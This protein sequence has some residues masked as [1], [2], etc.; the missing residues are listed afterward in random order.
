MPNI[1]ANGINLHYESFGED[2]A[3]PLVLIM[4]I[5]GQ[6]IQWDEDFC[7]ALSTEGFRV[8]RFDNRD[9]GMSEILDH[10]GTPDINRLMLQRALGSRIR[11]PYTLDD[12]AE[13]TAGL[14]DALGLQSAHIVGMSLGGMVAQ[15]LAL[16]HPQRVRSLGIIMSAPGELLPGLP[17]LKAFAALTYRSKQQ[18]EQAA[19]DYQLNFF[20]VVGAAPHRTP[21][22]RVRQLAAL[23]YQRGAHPRGFARQFAAILASPGRSRRL[24]DLRVPTV[25]LHGD[26][27]PLITHW[28]GR[29]IAARIPGA[30]LSIVENMGHDLGPTLWPYV[31]DQIKGNAQRTL[32]A[33]AQPMGLVRALTQPAVEVET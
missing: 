12:M 19:I 22:P 28:A 4:G 8:I 23:H 21:E 15:C 9:V 25:V 31:I 29:L 16:K 3:E 30:R 5:G 24:S 17:A 32:P 6:M 1:R 27:D 26:K 10:L 7:R 2:G 14:L 20:R 11:A 18:G 13:D 33:N